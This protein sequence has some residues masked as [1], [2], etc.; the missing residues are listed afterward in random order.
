MERAKADSKVTEQVAGARHKHLVRGLA[1]AA[2]SGAAS[3]ALVTGAAAQG[4]QGPSLRVAEA[5]AI[6]VPHKI[7][8][9][10]ESQARIQ[11]ALN[12]PITA[13]Y[14]DVS[15]GQ[16]LND[17]A[18]Q[19]EI[20]IIL[21]QVA[22]DRKRYRIFTKSVTVFE[23]PI[24]FK[25]NGLTLRSVLDLLCPS[26]GLSWDV[27]NGETISITTPDVAD[28]WLQEQVYPIAKILAQNPK[29]VTDPEAG[30]EVVS[31]FVTT[32][33]APDAWQIN[34]GDGEIVPLDGAL[35]VRSTRSVQNQVAAFLDQWANPASRQVQSSVAENEIRAALA[36]E[37]SLDSPE[38]ALYEVL[39]QLADRAGIPIVLDF[40]ALL[41]ERVPYDQPVGFNVSGVSLG[42]V[43]GLMLDSH[44]LA[45]VIHKDVLFVTTKSRAAD[46][47]SVRMY[48]VR[49]LLVPATQGGP[50]PLDQ[51]TLSTII[52]T[53]VR[54]ESWLA[55]GGPGHR[56]FYI[57]DDAK[58]V[59]L[60]V[61][62]TDEGHHALAERLAQ[63]RQWKSGD[64]AE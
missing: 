53:T 5:P 9:Q 24:I 49:D 1:L 39:P 56:E 57:S 8:G 11:A 15:F 17:L 19:A 29:S 46:L 34:G 13:D 2:L 31:S 23:A 7:S 20:P 59:L 33:V 4:L 28:K 43:L 45:A 38:Q 44:R 50:V 61:R 60:F 63:L 6:I 32:F 35:L 52:E 12:H 41:D 16:V 25:A 22:T 64:G 30:A 62:Q 36:S 37:I 40:Y 55:A 3:L 26:M 42:A 18:G 14:F 47:L 27:R 10:D 51:R 48:D 58:D 21:D 54:P